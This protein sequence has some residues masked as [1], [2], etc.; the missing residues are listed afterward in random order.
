MIANPIYGKNG[1]Y[2][3][4]VRKI[5]DQNSK[6]EGR[7]RSRLPYFTKEERKAIRGKD[8]ISSSFFV[9]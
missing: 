7:K 6:T 2:P 3:E 9:F 8:E 1:D 5:V 4:L